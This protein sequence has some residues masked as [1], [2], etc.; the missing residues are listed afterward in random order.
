M[1]SC[2]KRYGWLAAGPRVSRRG[3]GGRSMRV[4]AQSVAVL[5]VVSFPSHSRS[6]ADVHLLSREFF[7]A[8]HEQ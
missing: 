6:F 2:I 5:G 3:C 8:G 7:D 4:W 1:S